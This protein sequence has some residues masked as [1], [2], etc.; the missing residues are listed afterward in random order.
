[1]CMFFTGTEPKEQNTDGVW[2]PVFPEYGTVECRLKTFKQWAL[3]I[4]TLA[5]AGFFNSGEYFIIYCV[6]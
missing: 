5:K 1:M 2:N 6:L 3:P 4:E